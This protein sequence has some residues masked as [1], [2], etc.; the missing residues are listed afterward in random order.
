[1]SPFSNADCGLL[2]NSHGREG[3]PLECKE[4]NW[5]FYRGKLTETSNGMDR[6]GIRSIRVQAGSTKR[7]LAKKD[8]AASTVSMLLCNI[9][10]EVEP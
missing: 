10:K 3:A 5:L 2:H 1:M 4:L 8:C 7:L 9:T 6:A